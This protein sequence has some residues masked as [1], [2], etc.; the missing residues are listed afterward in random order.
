[1]A[2]DKLGL[3]GVPIRPKGTSSSTSSRPVKGV[4]GMPGTGGPS[5]DDESSADRTDFSELGLQLAQSAAQDGEEK[6][7]ALTPERVA[8]LRTKIA[9]DYYESPEVTEALA[10]ALLRSF[11]W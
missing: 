1:M 4:D 2:I 6:S 5:I 10:L 7:A 8:E 9:E 11:S 3:G